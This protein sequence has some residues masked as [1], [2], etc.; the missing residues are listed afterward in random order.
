MDCMHF[1]FRPTGMTEAQL[2]ALFLEFY[3]R[4]FMRPRVLFGY[5]AML[6]KSP[7]SWRR[8]LADATS[9]LKFA[10]HNKRW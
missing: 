3:K 4:H 6:W 5:L 7:D 8:F 9:F 2:Q 10:R 1:L